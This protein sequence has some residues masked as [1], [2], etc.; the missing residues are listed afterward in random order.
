MKNMI[1]NSMFS[2]AKAV[3]IVAAARTPIGTFQGKLGK[4][5]ATELGAT[6]IR[7]AY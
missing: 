3:Y 6:A 5:K 1:S 2:S 7:G 4:I